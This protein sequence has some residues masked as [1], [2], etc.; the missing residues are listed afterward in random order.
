MVLLIS[1]VKPIASVWGDIDYSHLIADIY[2]T[3]DGRLI[4]LPLDGDKYNYKIAT[5]IPKSHPVRSMLDKVD[6]PGGI[7]ISASEEGPLGPKASDYDVMQIQEALA[8]KQ[9]NKKSKAAGPTF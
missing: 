5:E 6:Q 1:K 2:T 4:R 9:Q 8:L 7:Q 3:H